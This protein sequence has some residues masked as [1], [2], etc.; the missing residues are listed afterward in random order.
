MLLPVVLA[1]LVAVPVAAGG[2]PAGPPG[3]GSRVGPPG[4]TGVRQM[5]PTTLRGEI[6]TTTRASSWAE[7][8]LNSAYGLPVYFTESSSISSWPPSVLSVASPR[9]SA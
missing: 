5:L 7:F 6:R 1:V 9:I 2:P 8:G 3:Y 4:G